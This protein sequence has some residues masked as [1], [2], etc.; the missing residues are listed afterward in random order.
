MGDYLCNVMLTWSNFCCSQ[1]PLVNFGKDGMN[2]P[3]HR[4]A[5]RLIEFIDDSVR[6][7]T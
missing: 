5:V 3:L 2:L 7:Y 6:L 1:R 4:D